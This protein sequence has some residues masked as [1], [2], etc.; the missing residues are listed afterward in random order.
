MG[1]NKQRFIGSV[2]KSKAKRRTG[3]KPVVR[4]KGDVR[5][6]RLPKDYRIPM[7]PAFIQ[8][9]EDALEEEPKPQGEQRMRM[10]AV[11][12]ADVKAERIKEAGEGDGDRK[13]RCKCDDRSD[14][15]KQQCRC[16]AL[17][18]FYGFYELEGKSWGTV[19]TYLGA[20]DT[21]RRRCT[22]NGSAARSPCSRRSSMQ[23]TCATP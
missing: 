4:E 14:E 13:Y 19:G 9:A 3:A 16:T 21:W 5:R 10:F 2:A 18:M 17:K 15:Q 22:R 1:S 11:L 6:M 7:N 12:H 8:Q 23:R 20:I